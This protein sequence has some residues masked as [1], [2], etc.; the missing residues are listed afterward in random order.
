MDGLW[1]R[2]AATPA[3]PNTDKTHTTVTPTFAT[4]TRNR[5]SRA[6][7]HENTMKTLTFWSQICLGQ[8]SQPSLPQ[9]PPRCF[10]DAPDASQMPP[11]QD[12]TA[13]FPQPQFH[14]QDSTEWIPHPGCYSQ[15][16]AARIP[17]PRLHSQD[18]KV[19][20]PQSRLRSQDST[21]RI[22]QS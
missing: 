6:Q 4:L 13:W 19:R 21:A 15:V 14:S 5:G 7:I 9:M 2:R 3:L 17:Q 11:S 16:S 1:R 20:I 8:L 12:S 10:P 18:S 22:P